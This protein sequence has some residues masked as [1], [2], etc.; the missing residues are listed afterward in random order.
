MANVKGN[1]SEQEFIRICKM[2][3]T[4]AEGAELAG[5][6]PDRFRKRRAIIEKKYGI[7]LRQ[8]SIH[9]RVNEIGFSNKDWSVAWD[10]SDGL[11]VLV[12]NPD[13]TPDE[14]KSA[15]EETVDA[16]KAIAPK[17]PTIKHSKPKDAHC[18]V[19][20][21]TDLHFGGWGLDRARNAV[22]DATTD[23]ISRATPY[24]LERIIFV[25]GSD[26]LHTDTAHYTT[27]KGTPVETDG[28]TWAQTFKA[29]QLAYTDCI[30]TL[31]QIAPVHVVHVSGNHD[32]LMSYA[33]AQVIEATFSKTKNITFDVSDHPRKYIR[34]HDNLL[35]F[36]HGDKV[37][38]TDLPMIVS[39]EAAQD[40]GAT[41]FRYVYM[42]HIH[43]NKQIKY[44]SI[45]EHPGIV[46]QWLRS[47]KPTDNWHRDRG[48]LGARGMTSFI[49]SRDGG[50]VASLSINL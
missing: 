6:H 27:S 36:T 4:N 20:N 33:L 25:I 43:H 7:N 5:V 24:P 15:L 47:P 34:F 28:S 41:K 46:L 21:A 26:C 42:G 32:E 50:Q 10:K 45:K 44:Q 12:H 8:S 37:K 9:E 3:K 16:I 35:C 30:A 19:I 40:W 29:A 22:L 49:H 48:F 2:V 38:D 23:A 11:S 13:F 1:V 17:F 31:V 18:L 39:H 14:Y